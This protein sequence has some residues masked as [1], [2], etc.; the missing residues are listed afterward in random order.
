MEEMVAGMLV[1]EFV[2]EVLLSLLADVLVVTEV[3]EL[4][5]AGANA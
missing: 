1:L 4:E 2:T 5:Y 3:D